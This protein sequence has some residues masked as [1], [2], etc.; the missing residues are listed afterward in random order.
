M[1]GNKIVSFGFE[2]SIPKKL[3]NH[4]TEIVSHKQD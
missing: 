4:F 2:T 3:P 1:I